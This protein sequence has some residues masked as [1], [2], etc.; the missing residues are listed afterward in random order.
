MK[1]DLIR[2]YSMLPQGSRVLCA[3]SGGADSMCLL[4]W[5]NELRPVYDFSLFAAHYEHGLRGGESLRDAEFTATQCAGL[6]ICC[7]VGHGDVAAYAEE[8][9]L[10]TEDAARTLRYRFLEETADR[11]ACDRP[12]PRTGTD[13]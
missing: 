5:L 12:H 11:L 1:D 10:G 6:G 7:T 4:H 3:V 8:H 2:R 13:R 9:R